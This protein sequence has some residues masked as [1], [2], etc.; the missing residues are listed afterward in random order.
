[1]KDINFI[2]GNCFPEGR[3]M[4]LLAF[5]PIRCSQR[6]INQKRSDTESYGNLGQKGPE[7]LLQHPA[8]SKANFRVRSDASLFHPAEF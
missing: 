8:Q 7:L 4:S 6:A 2:N 3:P 5:Y 1:M